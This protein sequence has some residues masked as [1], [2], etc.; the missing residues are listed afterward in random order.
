MIHPVSTD[1][2]QI[3]VLTTDPVIQVVDTIG[4]G[5]HIAELHHMTKMAGETVH[6]DILTTGTALTQIV[7][8]T[9]PIVP[10]ILIANALQVQVDELN[11]SLQDEMASITSRETGIS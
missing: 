6:P 2:R 7:S 11:F 10:N 9:D 3:E 8:M 1:I 5:H 4:T